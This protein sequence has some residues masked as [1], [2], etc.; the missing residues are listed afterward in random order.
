MI[1]DKVLWIVEDLIL[2]GD[3]WVKL[4]MALPKLKNWVT[5]LDLC[6]Y[7]NL[8]VIIIILNRFL[9]IE[10]FIL[11]RVHI[12]SQF[13]NRLLVSLYFFKRVYRARRFAIA[14][15]KV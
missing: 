12:G 7:K 4:T 8:K 3:L 1:G 10:Q 11:K 13:C 6:Y 15:Y 14:I 5:F 2:E 9:Y